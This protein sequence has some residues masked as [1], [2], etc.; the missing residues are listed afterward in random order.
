MALIE[1]VTS[2]AKGVDTS[3]TAG[4]TR[5]TQAAAQTFGE[6]LARQGANAGAT[7]PALQHNNGAVNPQAKPGGQSSQ[8]PKACTTVAK[9]GDTYWGFAQKYHTMPRTL[10]RLNPNAKPRRIQI[11][12][13]INLPGS[14]CQPTSTP[15]APPTSLLSG[16]AQKVD[17][18]V[19]QVEAAQ[20]SLDKLQALAAKGNGAA[21]MELR[22]G[23][24]QQIVVDSKTKLKAAINDEITSEIGANA[25]DAAV[26]KAGQEIAA[27]YVKDPAASKLVNDAVTQVRT[28]RQVQSI[29]SQAQT[30]TDPVKALQ[31]L[32]DGYKNA[33]QAVK[34]AILNDSNAQ[35]IIGNAAS[36][37]NQPLTQKSN[38]AIFPQ[39]KTYAAIERLDH[40]TQG[41]DKTLAGTVADKAVS[42]YEQFVKANE[43]TAGG[44][45]FASM[46][47]TTLMN[48]SGRITGT[49]QGNDAISRFAALNG[50]NTNS[51][52]NAIGDGADPAYAIEFAW[53]MKAAGQDPSIVVQA[54]NDGIA[55]RD[56]QKIAN[57]GDINPTLDVAKR[58]QAA[59]LDSS[60]VMKVAT[61]GAQGFKDKITSDVQKLA[62]H[63]AQLAWLVKN[64][65]AGLSPQ[66]LSQ[67][68]TAYRNSKGAAWRADEAK[69]MK[70]ISDD[71]TALLNQMTAL[72]QAA[73]AGNSTVDKTLKAI[74]NDP[75]AGLA[76]SSALQTNPALANGAHAADL[77]NL[78]SMAKIGDISRKFTGELASS[79]L[80]AR[81]LDKLEGVNMHDP[82]SVQQAKQAIDSLRDEKF[83]RMIGVTQKDLNKA[84]DEVKKTA[85]KIS[86]ANTQEEANAALQDLNNRLNTD[87]S[88][89]KTFNKTTFA[90][91]IFRGVAVAFAGASLINSYNKFNANPSDPQNGI[92]LLL[93]SAGFAQKNSELLVGLGTVSKGSA[94]G[95]FGG[96]WKLL[97]RASAGD[98]ISGISA[99]LDGV[100]AVRS[101]FG[102][103]V[104]QD[105]GNAIF[106][107]ITAVGG[108]L[109]VAPALGAS[110]SLGGIGLAIAAV[111][112]VGKMAYDAYKSAHQYEGVSK[113]F[114]K[115]AGYDDAAA[116]ALSKQ[117]GI[118]S[119]A[120][121]SAQM[122]FLAKYAQYKHL[123]PNQLE[124]WINSLTPDQVKHLSQRLLQTAGDS[125]GDPNQF[126]DGPPQTAIISGGG[127]PAIITLANTVGVFDSYLDYD[128]VTHP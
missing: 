5:S 88:L 10:E 15:K 49:T 54:I 98:L 30:Q 111:G 29:V 66:Q 87:A 53:R 79:F 35:K 108:G 90:G 78:F 82:A 8:A 40:A 86:A 105:T 101:G 120:S 73:P 71:G 70:Q 96:E 89:S 52:V 43:N 20:S 18:A 38:D 50:W 64:D 48:L 119:G 113:D 34:D 39:S 93:D 67:A 100:S 97:G 44:S 117:D 33:P 47:V 12:Q 68:I 74:A 124:K 21:R 61:D 121:G 57:G 106:S 126:T 13:T 27:R 81:V 91:Q 76:I 123:T 23:S 84:I 36:W 16:P 80:R 28:Y 95:Q 32:N 128:H 31:T 37:A 122:P 65:G 75:S 19:H 6:Q 58:M 77:G 85:D 9:P 62:G 63:D 7:N 118:L 114:L 104:P 112:V 22:D 94:I 60:G 2:G 1:D 24:A 69:L 107:G 59:G 3:T 109:S 72:N 45:P 17:N 26:A 42:G 25:S 103:G 125:N 110:A 4:E 51:V 92:K 56:E 11:G 46:G 115:A 116:N 99:V 102:L 55:M 83:A 41:L 127:Y 14:V